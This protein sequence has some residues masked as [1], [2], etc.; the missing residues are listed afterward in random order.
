MRGDSVAKRSIPPLVGQR[1][2][3]RPVEAGDLPLTLAWR[4]R[5]DIR[6]WFKTSNLLVM[7]QHAAWFDRYLTRDDDFLFLIEEIDRL[8]KPIGQ[9]GLYGIDWRGGTAELGRIMVGE[10]DALGA[11]FAGEATSLLLGF[12]FREWG[13]SEVHLEVFSSNARAIRVYHRC[14]FEA[15]SEEDGLLRMRVTADRF[16]PVTPPSADPQANGSDTRSAILSVVDGAG[17][18][19]AARSRGFPP[20]A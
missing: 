7:D 14:G 2:R 20:K 3:L 6:R 13:L 17:E 11:G 12:A 9:V 4:N 8:R 5:D 1:L 16:P 18:R 10:P 19:A 15:V